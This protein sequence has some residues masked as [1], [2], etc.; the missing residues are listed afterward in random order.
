MASWNDNSGRDP[1]PRGKATGVAV[2]IGIILWLI[3]V[4]VTSRAYGYEQDIHNGR[5]YSP[6]QSAVY[7]DAFVERVT[8][9]FAVR[10]AYTD[11]AANEAEWE[12][13]L[14]NAGLP[15][16]N[17]GLY[18]HGFSWPESGEVYYSPG[19]CVG[20][21]R[22]LV[23]NYRRLNPGKVAWAMDVAVHEAFHVR[24][25]SRDEAAV[26]ACAAK[27]L[28]VALNRFYRIPYR[29]AEMRLLTGRALAMRSKLPTSYRNG[30][31]PV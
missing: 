29:T 30:R 31:C 8:D 16:N 15:P 13:T 3:A 25:Q 10:P 4:V 27:Y 20:L 9:Y 2:I 11:C 26:E 18:Y 21:R 19:V 24:L 28:P 14:M 22:G 6:P 7:T 17:Q 1:D 23:A 12:Q 5:R